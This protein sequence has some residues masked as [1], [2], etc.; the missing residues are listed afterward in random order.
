MTKQNKSRTNSG[1]LDARD[2]AILRHV[3]LYGLTF[4]HPVQRL[5]FP[6]AE[7]G[8]QETGPFASRERSPRLGLCKTS[9][10][11]IQEKTYSVQ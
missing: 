6:A 5:F 7:F 4:P 1:E 9:H 3:G 11:D 10:F 2:S 8:G